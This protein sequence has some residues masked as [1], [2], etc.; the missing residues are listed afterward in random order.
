MSSATITRRGRATVQIDVW[1]DFACPC[2]LAKPR[3]DA[4]IA[5]TGRVGQT[6]VRYHAWELFPEAA[7]ESF[8][9]FGHVINKFGG[10][11]PTPGVSRST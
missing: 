8:D 1:T 10:A 6:A 5:A 2:Y 9:S 3:L 11:R 4:A 7:D